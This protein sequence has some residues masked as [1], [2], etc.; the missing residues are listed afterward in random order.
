MLGTAVLSRVGTHPLGILRRVVNGA[1]GSHEGRWGSHGVEHVWSET[2]RNKVGSFR[3]SNRT[4]DADVLLLETTDRK[5]L[6]YSRALERCTP[7]MTLQIP[8]LLPLCP[9]QLGTILTQHTP[10]PQ[11]KAG[12]GLDRCLTPI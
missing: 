1:R 6:A 9:V 2:C 8:K 5:Q 12:G 3:Q 4:T 10:L 7:P 11:I